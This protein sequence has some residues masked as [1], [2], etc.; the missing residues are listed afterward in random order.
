MT[1]FECARDT[2]QV[3]G[4]AEYST[5]PRRDAPIMSPRVVYPAPLPSYGKF[6]ISVR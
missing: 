5:C 4:L 2:D 3:R 1:S 6:S